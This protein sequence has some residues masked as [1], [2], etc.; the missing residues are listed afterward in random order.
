MDLKDYLPTE[1]DFEDV[2]ANLIENTDSE[3]RNEP[4]TVAMNVVSSTLDSNIEKTDE[5]KKTEIVFLK[6]N[7]MQPTLFS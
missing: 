3:K 1:A 4:L 6:E 2:F 7:I 5:V